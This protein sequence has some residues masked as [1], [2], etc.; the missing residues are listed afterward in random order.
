MS[1]KIRDGNERDLEGI[2]SLRRMVFGEME[3]DKLDPGV[4]KW[5]FIEDP[6]GR[7][8]LYIAENGNEVIGHFADLPRRFSVGGEEVFATLSLDLMV[9]PEYR[10][11]G[12]F[13]AL[14]NHGIQRVKSEKGLFMTAYPIRPETIGGLKKIGWREVVELPVLVYPIRF[15][16]IVNRYLHILPLSVL[17]GGSARFFHL[18][19]F[20]MKKRRAVGDINI[21]AV[22][23]F[24]IAFS[25]FCKKVQLSYPLVGVR[26]RDYLTWR[27]LNHPTRSYTIY[28]AWKAGE[29]QGY[30]VLRKVDLLQ[31]NS[32][33]MVDRLSLDEQVLEALVEK[34]IEW[35]DREGADLLAFMV[36]K[37]HRCR[38]KLKKMGFLSSPR[39]FLFMIYPHAR[40]NELLQREK[41]YVT[42]GDT[43]VI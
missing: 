23:H 6:D 33:V 42:W 3:K 39:S 2:L 18:L 31:F 37:S 29:M 27:Y 43:D 25:D 12:I 38:R 36:P 21:E 26:D 28:R 17:L 35:G 19:F 15:H 9:H 5:E 24:D 40:G 7:G 14:G 10:R 34:G 30:I 13:A 16:G 41:W 8:F 22:E 32:A 20:G 1:W 11:Q 4:W